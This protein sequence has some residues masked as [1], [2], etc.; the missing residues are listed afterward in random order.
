MGVIET[1]SYLASGYKCFGKEECTHNEFVTDLASAF[2]GPSSTQ[3][4]GRL[5]YIIPL[6]L[7]PSIRFSRVVLEGREGFDAQAARLASGD[8]LLR[9]PHMATNHMCRAE[10]EHALGTH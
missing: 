8:V 5:R 10:V 1:N 9:I 3:M 2:F 6:W 4:W 7:T